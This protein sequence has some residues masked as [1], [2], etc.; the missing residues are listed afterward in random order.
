M[1]GDGPSRRTARARGRRPGV[2]R[3]IAL[4]LVLQGILVVIDVASADQVVFT[5]AFV[6]APFGLAVTGHAR[7]TA[8][9]AVLAVILAIASGYWNHYAGSTDHFLRITI[10]T[11]GG[12]LATLAAAAL[13]KAAEQRGRMAILASVGRLSSAHTLN[14]AIAGLAESLV[15]AAADGCWV[16]LIEPD[17]EPR[18]LFEH[19][20]DPP[21]AELSGPARLLEHHTR[22]VVPLLSQGEITGHLGLTTTT[23]AYDEEDLQFFTIVAGRVALVL[24]NAR[25]VS[26]LRSTRARLDGILNG[27]AEAVTVNDDQGRTIYANQA[28]TRLLGRT[29]PE[30]VT[31]ARP[32]ELAARFVITDEQGDPVNIDDFP[33]RRLVRNEPAP[34]MLTRT[35]D[36]TTGRAFWLLT[37][38][39]PLT[40]QGRNFAINII[41]DVTRAKEAEQRQRFLA[42][43]GQVLASSLDYEE[44]L[45]HVAALAVPWL[46]DWCAV[47]LPGRDGAIEQVALAHTD[48]EKVAMAN[49]LR[50]RYPPDPVAASGVPAVLAGAP[51]ELYKEIPDE[52]LEQLIDDPDQ[53]RAIRDIGMRSVMIVPMRSGEDTLGA[54]TFV[55]ADSGRRFDEDDFAF[56]QDLGLRAATAVQNARLYAAQERVAHTLQASLLPE[57][58]PHIAGFSIAA[59]YQAGELGAEVGGDFYDIVP[60][61]GGGHLIFLGD[62]TGKGIEAAALTSLVRHSVRTAARFDPRPGAILALVNEILAE[63]ARLSPV[64]LVTLHLHANELTIAAAGHPPPLLRRHAQQN[65]VTA[66]GPTGILLGVS[67][68]QTFAEETT[69]LEPGDAVLLYTD[70][71]TDTPGTSDRFGTDR[72]AH[73]LEHA[74]AEPQKIL[75]TIDETLKAFQAGTAIDDRALL[76][77]AYR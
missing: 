11:V 74:P 5:T 18:R 16:D 14:D 61:A 3:W 44:T 39:S 67:P 57:E 34:E 28:A 23:G 43:A 41:E 70:G 1:A 19:G 10:V 58:I 69:I 6:L 53:L 36:K 47:D 40:D 56:A 24:A 54:I 71:V 60:T 2:A 38:A 59:S 50:R 75:D 21:A 31:R 32:G 52:L 26:D 76:L 27:L 15:P 12:I 55:T 65:A 45:R 20:A 49:E 62:V 72:L 68:G 33:G 48:P 7:A 64:T 35:I 25:L 17:G 63:Q 51:A 13:E 4:A 46:A 73:T 66:I 22:A 37:K 42:R 8:A 29:S 30:E 9:M 77:V